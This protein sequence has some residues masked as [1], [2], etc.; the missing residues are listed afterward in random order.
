MDL[1]L[2]RLYREYSSGNLDAGLS[3]IHNYLRC[4]DLNPRYLEL[5]A[6]YGH[7]LAMYWAGRQPTENEALPVD[8]GVM[9]TILP[10]LYRRRGLEQ[11]KY[12]YQILG[13]SA[14][15][16]DFNYWVPSL[17]DVAL[18]GNAEG[19]GARN[20]SVW[21]LL[22]NCF[23]I[24]EELVNGLGWNYDDPCQNFSSWE[25]FTSPHYSATS[26]DQFIH[27]MQDP[28]MIYLSAMAVDI[29]LPL[30][31]RYLAE[32]CMEYFLLWWDTCSEPNQVSRA[33]SVLTDRAVRSA[34]SHG[35][36]P[37]FGGLYL[38]S[39]GE[40]NDFCIQA[41]QRLLPFLLGPLAYQRN[42]YRRNSDEKLRR[43]ERVYKQDP[44]DENFTTLQIEQ[45]RSGEKQFFHDCQS[46]ILLESNSEAERDYYY[47]PKSSS[48][49]GGSLLARF[50]SE[51]P[52]Y[53]SYPMIIARRFM[54]DHPMSRIVRLAREQGFV[55]ED[56]CR[57]GNLG[58][59]LHE[60]GGCGRC[61]PPIACLCNAC[62]IPWD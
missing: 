54:L 20:I 50:G 17:A 43:L 60:H 42:P 24:M 36:E 40:F 53:A 26:A 5:A 9:T 23:Q 47:C 13:T 32:A 51:G 28:P 8:S 46:C 58:N 57:H 6:A 55:P 2:R 16:A 7:P 19:S 61:M 1:R 3:L 48:D 34:V 30:P 27:N 31:I 52:E 11:I 15:G 35:D 21:G 29:S 38:Y 10:E 45:I 39:D 33:V 37:L 59:V 25:E 56:V 41:G 62:R 14:V 4:N 18:D 22:S 12:A 44:T 49:M